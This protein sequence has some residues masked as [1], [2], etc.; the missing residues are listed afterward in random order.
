M[1][2]IEVS[3]PEVVGVTE[4]SV[5]LAFDVRSGGRPVDAEV[6]ITAGGEVR[7]RSGGEAGT[8]LVRLEGL[9]PATE[10]EIG[11]RAPGLRAVPR[12]RYFPERVRTLPAP[13][14]AQVGCFATLNDIHIGEP[15]MGGRLTADF[16]Y[17]EE[18]P[19]FPVVRAEDSTAYLKVD[20]KRLDEGALRHCVERSAS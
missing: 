6:E 11:F 15:R 9:P 18:A 17:G 13:G 10:V 3:H 16:E 20:A 1:A 5:T 4:S 19:G 12:D 8:R 14:G 7:A 2:E